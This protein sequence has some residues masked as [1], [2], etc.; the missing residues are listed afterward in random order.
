MN[1]YT[2]LR[3]EADKLR[4]EIATLE[5]ADNL[6]T[7]AGEQLDAAYTRLEEIKPDLERAVAR[8]SALNAA[9]AL[10]V[11]VN[12]ATPAA[13]GA[14]RVRGDLPSSGEYLAEVLAIGAAAVG[15]ADASAAAER[16]RAWDDL[17]RAPVAGQQAIADNL[18][19]IPQ[20]VVSDLVK[21]VDAERYLINALG[22]RPM[23]KGSGNRPRVTQTSQVGS[24]TAEFTQ[25]PARKLLIVRDALTRLTRAG[26]VEIS[27]QDDE[28]SEPGMLQIILQ[29]LAE[30]YGVDTDTVVCAALVTASTNTTEMAGAAAAINTITVPATW[31]A[32]FAA[33]SSTVFTNSRKLPT[34]LMVSPD[35]W[36]TLIGLVDSSG[37]P[38]Y[39]NLAPHNSAGQ[40]GGVV[41][42][43]APTGPFGLRFL[44]DP[45]F[46]A[47]TAIVGNAQYAEVYEAQRGIV[48]GPFLPN[49]LST[50]I[51][52]YGFLS[53]YMRAEGFAR[54][55]NAV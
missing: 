50:D 45:N 47:N 21:F 32:A 30:Q 22:V 15:G 44:V 33:A 20:P 40:M 43:D 8:Q 27:A 48:T 16:L 25:V 37:R 36:G 39:P 14:D 1:A 3:A 41:T 12:G 11:A 28:F 26:V 52:Y 5:S 34:H 42:F 19:V 38:V 54:L 31:A 51:G 6:S 23:F 18:G 4:A 7:E 17:M 49:T 13:A 2:A 55:V 24:Q 9:A 53:T 35:V 10:T 29:D 46:A